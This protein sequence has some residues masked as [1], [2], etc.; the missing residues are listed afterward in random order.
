MTA[1]TAHP[2]PA[3]LEVWI[4]VEC[5]LNRVQDQYLHQLDTCGHSRR[6]DDLDL[7]AGLGARR[8]RYPVLWE[9][10]A[11][12]DPEQPDWRWTDE[13][14][15]R[16]RE[17]D[18]QPIATLLHHGS[19]PEYTDLLD[20]HFPEKL[21]AYARKVAERYPW[22]RLYTPVNEPL[23][24]ARFSGLYGVWYP[25]HTSDA[26]FVR[27]LLNE[28][29]GTVLAMRAIREVQP[30]AQL[31]QTDD[32][33][34]T[35]ATPFMQPEAD[36]QNDRRWLAYDLLC[37]RVDEQHPLWTYLLQ[38]GATPEE[39]AWLRHNP[40]PPDIVGVDYYV[41]SERFLDE[42]TERYAGHH[43]CGS[44]YA[45]IEAVRVYEDLAGIEGLLREVWARYRLPIAITEAHLGSTREEQLRWFSTFWQAAQR[46]RQEGVEV[47]AVT[48][49]AVLGS[50][51]WNTLHTELKGHYEPG[52][53]D[54]RGPA[55]R[56]TALATLLRDCADGRA[57]P[58][59]VLASPGFWDRPDRYFFPVVRS[60]APRRAPSPDRTARPLLIL[61][62][63]ALGRSVRRLCVER[64]LAYQLLPELT[65]APAI[66][67]ALQQLDPWAVVHTA[68]YGHI[69]AAERHR[70]N[71]W[72]AQ[73][74]GL[75]VL[76]RACAAG[77][78]QLLSFSSDQVFAGERRAPY[79]ELDTP[80]PVNAYGRAKLEAERQALA[81]HPGTLIVRSAALFGPAERWSALSRALARVRTGEVIHLDHQ[82]AFSPTYMPDLVHA[83]LDLLIDGERGIWHLVNDGEMTWSDF[84][85]VVA[86][87]RGL[88][89][90]AVQPLLGTQPGWLAPRPRYS[91]LSSR[92][93]HLMPSFERAL[94]RYLADA[95]D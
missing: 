44:E 63:G 91:A 31:V 93:G 11:P 47:L 36:F 79:H 84:V 70:L 1:P 50:F 25:H 87:A 74:V 88:P 2:A 71:F 67:A 29:R 75:A 17:L 49:W 32:L 38:A 41:T 33:G 9:M 6:P 27:M 23:T 14:L 73:A 60:S 59:P 30:Q 56:P 83:S 48:S 18:L 19:G 22:L 68:G 54:V 51:D 53:F 15:T 4:G 86:E 39:L 35:H 92:R 85:R 8:I 80:A 61:G 46:V 58:H 28:C 94:D 13:R 89:G 77:G 55:P 90:D 42:R 26:S 12:T 62:Q 24:T 21:A 66:G 16:L 43:Q 81:Y 5:T 64:G 69:D 78:V 52:A 20:P 7:L 34:K 65:D 82:H 95:A 40:C 10:V 76:A 45:D 37:G 3:P 72:R 57:A